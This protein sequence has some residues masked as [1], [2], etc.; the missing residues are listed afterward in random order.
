MNVSIYANRI[1]KGFTIKG[2]DFKAEDITNKR[3]IS[4][5]ATATK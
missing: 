1:S 3:N 2:V 4:L 5:K